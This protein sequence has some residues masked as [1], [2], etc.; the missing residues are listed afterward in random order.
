MYDKVSL[1]MPHSEPIFLFS[2]AFMKIAPLQM[3]RVIA[4][5]SIGELHDRCGKCL[6][7]V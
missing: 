3:P 1:D 2:G 5:S 7:F 6:N 4:P